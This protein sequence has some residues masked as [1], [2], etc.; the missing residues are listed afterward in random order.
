MSREDQPS[1]HTGDVIE[2]ETE[3]LAFGGEAVARV[4]GLALFIP[5]AAPGERLKVRVTQK[6]KNFARALIEEIIRPSVDRRAPLC[7]HFGEC[8]GCQLQ[9]ISYEAQIEAKSAFIRDSL[10]RIGHI[11]WKDDIEIRRSIEYGYRSRAQIKVEKQGDRLRI[12][13]NRR[14]SHS[15]CDIESCPVLTDE[16]NSSLAQLRSKLQSDNSPAEFEIAAGDAGVSISPSLEG[17]TSSVIERRIG[18]YTYRFSPSVFFQANPNLLEGMIIEAV[19]EERGSLAIDL[20]A[21]VGLFTL[22]MSRLYKRVIGIEFDRDAVKLAEENLAENKIFNVEYHCAA[23]ERW[24]KDFST[25]EAIDF[26]LL[27]PPRGGAAEAI[28]EIARLQPKRIAYVSCDPATLAR[29]LR[30]LLDAGFELKRVVGFDL[31]P[32]TYHVETI[33]LLARA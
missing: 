21:G 6:K 22:P 15:V 26:I 8:G 23:V 1:L 18:E 13:F 2:V 19:G 10:R 33:V 29:D 5:L 25:A 17:F 9:H 7:T 4:G 16:I 11:E 32:Q 31:F 27:D 28:R 12:G 30:S 20:F 14:L 3:R 24:L